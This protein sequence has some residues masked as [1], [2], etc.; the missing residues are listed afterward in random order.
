MQ[1]LTPHSFTAMQGKLVR[2]NLKSVRAGGTGR[3]GGG[4]LQPLIVRKFSGETLMIRARAK[5]QGRKHSK[6]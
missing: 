2:L 1:N 5:V 3:R 6:R 4:G